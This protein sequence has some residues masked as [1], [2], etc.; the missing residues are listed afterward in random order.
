MNTSQ[1]REEETPTEH[2]SPSGR[3]Q[4]VDIGFKSSGQYHL[5]GSTA[6]EKDCGISRPGGLTLV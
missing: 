5:E 1:I 3:I 4:E 6:L 2:I